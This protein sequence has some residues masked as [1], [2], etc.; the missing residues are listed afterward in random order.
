MYEVGAGCVVVGACVVVGEALGRVVVGP[1]SLP[2]SFVS[3]LSVSST[4][5][6]VTLTGRVGAGDGSVTTDDSDESDVSGRVVTV[7]DGAPSWLVVGEWMVVGGPRAVGP[8]VTWL[9]TLP[10]AAAAITTATNVAASQAPEMPKKLLIP[11]VCTF[12]VCSGLNEG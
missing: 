12:P 3:E 7:V 11:I 4:V 1:P 8:S 2:G 9:R 6:V 5:V 10:T